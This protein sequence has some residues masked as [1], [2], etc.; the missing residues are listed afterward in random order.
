MIFFLRSIAF[1]FMCICCQTQAQ[2]LDNSLIAYYPFDGTTDDVSRYAH[3]GN[4][5]NVSYGLDHCGRPNSA[6]FLN[7]QDAYVRLPLLT[8]L[9]RKKQ[10]TITAWVKP[11]RF[12]NVQ[13]TLKSVFSHWIG[14]GVFEPIGLL[15]GVSPD[16]SVV[17]AFSGGYQVSSTYGVVRPD[18]WQLIALVYDGTKAVADDRATFQVDCGIQTP[19]CDN[20]YS[21]CRATPDA[22]GALAQYSYVGTRRNDLNQFVDYYEGYIDDLRIYDRLLTHAQLNDLFLECGQ[23]DCNDNNPDTYDTFNSSTCNC[24]H[25]AVNRL[26]PGVYIPSAFTPNHDGK[27]DS[28]S[29]V[30]QQVKQVNMTVFN[31]WGEIIFS[32]TDLREGWDGMFQGNA[33][34]PGL[35]PYQVSGTY[36]TGEAFTFQGSVTL[37]R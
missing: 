21:S 4:P 30:Y 9:N 34:T 12:N 15:F 13:Y 22:I 14:Y 27:N 28:F 11:R 5:Q 6:I 10:L 31:R 23:P 3:H 7:G 32:G 19:T 24:E 29:P 37:L 1:L 18:E 17:G 26:M 25:V 35:Y 36:D 2:S 8:Q 16:R 33:C 20:V